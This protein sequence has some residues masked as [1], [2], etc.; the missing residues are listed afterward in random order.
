MTEPRVPSSTSDTPEEVEQVRIALARQMPAW[1]KLAIVSAKI[2]TCRQL[3]LGDS[4]AA[5]RRHLLL[6]WISTLLQSRWT[7]T[8]SARSTGATRWRRATSATPTQAAILAIQAAVELDVS[9]LVGGSLVSS[10][11]GFARATMDRDSVADL[12]PEHGKPW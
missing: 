4:A 2:Q 5:T 6:N 11:R 3:A 8:L 10:V 7:E 12:K 9:Y 1:R